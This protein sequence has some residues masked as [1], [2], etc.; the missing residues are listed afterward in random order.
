ML[1]DHNFYMP[2]FFRSV[3]Q[4]STKQLLKGILQSMFMMKMVTLHIER[5]IHC[6][7]V[8]IH[9]GYKSMKMKGPKVCFLKWCVIL[10]E[11]FAVFSQWKRQLM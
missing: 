3:G 2:I 8:N 4:V 1:L 11:K 10:F 5:Y 9:S 6:C 7:A